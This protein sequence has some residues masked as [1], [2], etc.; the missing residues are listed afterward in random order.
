[1]GIEKY[2]TDEQKEKVKA[3]KSPDEI[4]A[5]LGEMGVELPDK[6]LDA[7]AGG[8]GDSLFERLLASTLG[9]QTQGQGPNIPKDPY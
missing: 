6:L 8:A 3:C 7:V 9:I 2:L 4:I 1:M 5:L